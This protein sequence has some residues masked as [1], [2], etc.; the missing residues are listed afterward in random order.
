VLK[1]EGSD[2]LKSLDD[3]NFFDSDNFTSPFTNPSLLNGHD[4]DLPTFSTLAPALSFEQ[5]KQLHRPKAPLPG[6]SPVPTPAASVPAE[7]HL[8]IKPADK[9]DRYLLAAADQK[10][11]S[12][13]ERLA[14]V[15]HAKFEAGLL[16]PYD[17]VS[18]YKRLMRWMESHV[19]LAY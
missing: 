15:I 13:D 3:P 6:P 19:S 4:P 12:R 2:F 9:N 16:K 5:Q 1:T 17:Y 10:D 18:G 8:N 7:T 11:G 14:R